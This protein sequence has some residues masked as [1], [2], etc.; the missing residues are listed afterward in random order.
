V[1]N[2][3][4]LLENIETDRRFDFVSGLK[5][6]HPN[7]RILLVGGI[8]RDA[9]IGRNNGDYDFVVEGILIDDLINDLRPYGVVIEIGGRNFGVI[10]F[11]PKGQKESFD[12]AVPRTERYEAGKRAHHAKMQIEN[13]TLE[14]DFSRRDFTVNAIGIDPESKAVYDPF[15]G[16]EDIENKIIRAVNNPR[17][18]FL[19]DP[20]RILRGIRLAIT[21]GFNIESGTL[22]AMK[23]LKSE[24]VKEFKDEKG[25]KVTRVSAEVIGREISQTVFANPVEF[26]D[27]YD[28]IGLLE[29]LLPEVVALKKVEQPLEWHAE[30]DAYVH[31]RLLLKNLPSDSSLELKLAGLFHDIGKAATKE[32]ASTGQRD[33]R[34]AS[35]PAIHFYGHDLV[36]AEKAKEILSRYCFNRKTIESVVWQIR[37]HL[38]I[39]EFSK[40]RLFKQK[41]MARQPEFSN[42]VELTKADQAASIPRSAVREEFLPAVCQILNQIQEDEKRGKPK[43]ILNGGEIV[44]FLQLERP[45]FDPKKEGRL[46]GQLK[47]K[48]NRA[49]DEGKIRTK[50]EAVRWLKKQGL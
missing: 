24:I 19:E 8:V 26:L 44:E 16:V 37:N 43:E 25:R 21:L 6:A 20:T 29:L 10:K 18:R 15:G 39:M 35:Q 12:I 30:G 3:A 50:G 41:E 45:G 28:Q 47:Q 46:I 32:T 5:T 4:E 23:E 33:N 38:R 31:T 1:K 42:L 40:M 27:L 22:A 9:L 7:T 49:Y 11:R 48:V 34:S 36:S 2:I 17:E 14:K 13:V